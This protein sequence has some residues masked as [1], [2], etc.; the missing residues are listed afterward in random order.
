MNA[1][2][3]QPLDVT[4]DDDDALMFSQY[5][6]DEYRDQLSVDGEIA[7]YVKYPGLLVESIRMLSGDDWT[8]SSIKIWLARAPAHARTF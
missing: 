5:A 6:S 2:D 3:P 4:L 7:F 1:M 8:W